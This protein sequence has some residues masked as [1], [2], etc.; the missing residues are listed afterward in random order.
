M[1]DVDVYCIEYSMIADIFVVQRKQ[2]VE[3][4]GDKFYS[5]KNEKEELNE[6]VDKIQ[7]DI[8]HLQELPEY[9]MS[10]S[11][12]NLLYST[13]R[14][15]TIVETSHD[16]SFDTKKKLYFPDYFALISEYQRQNFS[17]LDIPIQIVE[18][19]IEYKERGDRRTGLEKLGLNP[20]LKHVL[21]VGLFSPRKNQKEIF[22]YAKNMLNYPVQFHFVGNQASNFQEY[23]SPLMKDIPANVKIWGEK[24]NVSD[25]Y[26]CMDLFL[27][28]S[29]G[30][31]HDKETSPLVIREA[32]GHGIPSLIYNLPVYMG[33]YNKYHTIN[34]LDFENK[35]K[36]LSLIIDK[37]GFSLDLIDKKLVEE[38]IVESRFT[39]EYG[40]AEN[41][42]T[43]SYNRDLED[44]V[45]SVKDIDSNVVMWSV[46]HEK[47]QKDQ[48]FWTIPIP[49][50][51]YDCETEPTFGGFNVEIYSKGNFVD[52]KR[53]RIK[54]PS[55]EK[56]FIHLK[57]ITE[58][59]FFNYNEFF[60][61]KIYDPYLKGKSFDTVVDIGANVGMWVEYIRNVSNVKK[62]YA[63]EPNIN[64]LKILTD[65]FKDISI[66]DSALHYEDGK[67]SLYTND[68]NSTISAIQNHSTFSST[69]SV[70]A[71]TLK[72]FS[73][74]NGI[75]KID[76]LKVDIE[77]A[78]YDLFN[79]FDAEDF[80]MI[81]NILVE[82]HLLGNRY[83]KDVFELS[84]LL[85]E[86]GYKTH[87]RNMNS[88]GG[89][90]F[91]TKNKK[92][93]VGD[94]N[95]ILKILDSNPCPEKMDIANL[96]NKLYPNGVGIEIGVLRGDYSKIILDRW[97]NGTLYMVD[98]WRHIPEYIDLNGRDDTYHYECMIQTAK[99][100]KDHQHRAHMIRMDSVKCSELFPDEYFDFIY[101][102]ADHSYE[103]VQKDLQVWWPKIKKGGLFT[104]D[105]YIPEDGDIWLIDNN[106]GTKE[107]AGKFGVRKAVTE[108]A[109]EN[110]L[111]IYST[112]QEPYWKQWYTFKPF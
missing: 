49:K 81:E 77:S 87:M 41:K 17:K 67:L 29:R 34:Y 30:S 99:S 52:N 72:T 57:N 84:S 44:V 83:M 31:E 50:N 24:S 53:I 14:T 96:V 5:L 85:E 75:E 38:T 106:D 12:A 93:T 90:I 76:L 70:N 9:F 80:S 2:I 8:V 82:Y 69:Y 37:L 21:N 71:V 112:T 65:S 95:A 48:K 105:D 100:I 27:F 98:T 45:I 97:H 35:E 42:I 78:E 7:P 6:I 25:F 23:W 107:Y 56:P 40:N 104:G 101:I 108:F 28:T 111:Q 74:Q 109:E 4:L 16:S 62:V 32:I 18:S 19:D 66:I 68:D 43:Y 91:A 13:D 36:N 60:I 10:K 20:S 1:N 54:N 47:Y 94:N 102:D 11:V 79:S 55:V 103:A 39:V 64:A 59:T 92:F 15:Y 89:F 58:P 63:V 110:K 22:D 46:K 26:S 33:M 51:Y 88:V 86:N 3:L 73:K 61:D